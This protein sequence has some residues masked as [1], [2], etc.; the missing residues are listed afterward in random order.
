MLKMERIDRDDGG[1]CRYMN[2]CK[3]PAAEQVNLDA[4]LCPRRS[5]IV[6]EVAEEL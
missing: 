1:L 3:T 5:R 6:R 2:T 4:L